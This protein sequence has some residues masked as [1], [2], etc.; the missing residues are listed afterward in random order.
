MK[1]LGEYVI[2]IAALIVAFA[3]FYWEVFAIAGVLIKRLVKRM[4]A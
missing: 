2:P 4:L 3:V 1:Y